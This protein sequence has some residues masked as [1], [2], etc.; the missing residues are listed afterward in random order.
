MLEDENDGSDERLNSDGEQSDA[1]VE[2]D[3]VQPEI[4]FDAEKMEMVMEKVNE[5][6]LSS[7]DNSY[8]SIFNKFAEAHADMFNIEDFEAAEHVEGNL[9]WTNVHKSYV[10]VIEKYIEK[11]I[12]ECGISAEEFFGA[13]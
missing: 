2:D 7:D 1:P 10:Q 13:L 4:P 8:E 6:W 12:K 5:W 3:D 9:E 11:M